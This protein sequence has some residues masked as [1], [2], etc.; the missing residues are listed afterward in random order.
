MDA[1]A[2]LAVATLAATLRAVG[3]VEGWATAGWT[4]AASAQCDAQL[5]VLSLPDPF[6][7]DPQTP[8]P[9]RPRGPRP[10]LPRGGHLGGRRPAR[11]D[12]VRPRGRGR[13]RRGGDSRLLYASAAT[14]TS[15]LTDR[16]LVPATSDAA[17]ARLQ[18]TTLEASVPIALSHAWALVYGLG[19]VSGGSAPR[20]RCGRSARPGWPS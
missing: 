14:S 18:A 6:V 19:S 13:G 11:R 5:T 8:S 20:I 16:A 17:P 10:R 7:A 12:G 4:A 3:D 9:S 1:A 15:A 2:Q